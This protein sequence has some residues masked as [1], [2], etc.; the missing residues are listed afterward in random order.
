MR[1]Q[2]K[3]VITLRS[4]LRPCSWVDPASWTAMAALLETDDFEAHVELPEVRAAQLEFK[5][6]RSQLEEALAAMTSAH[7]LGECCTLLLQRADETLR[8][9]YGDGGSSVRRW[10]AHGGIVGPPRCM[11]ALF[12]KL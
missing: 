7:F 4:T 5:S 11:G 9:P 10:R 6:M 12:V 2:A 3:F 1:G 8:A